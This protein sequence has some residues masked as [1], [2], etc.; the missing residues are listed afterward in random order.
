MSGCF[1]ALRVNLREPCSTN[2][3]PF[4]PTDIST[5][6]ASREEELQT[7]DVAKSMPTLQSSRKVYFSILYI[8]FLCTITKTKFTNICNKYSGI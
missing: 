1:K 5:D 3:I 7:N 6:C 2:Q 4:R 8:T